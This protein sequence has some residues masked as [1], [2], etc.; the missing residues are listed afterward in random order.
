MIQECISKGTGF[1][2]LKIG[3]TTNFLAFRLSS[4]VSGEFPVYDLSSWADL[5]IK[6]LQIIV[7]HLQAILQ[8]YDKSFVAQKFAV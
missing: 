1:S 5:Y 7:Y 2:K 3:Y 4:S 6:K 8:I